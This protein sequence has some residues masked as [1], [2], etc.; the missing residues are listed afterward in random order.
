MMHSQQ[1]IK[2][3]QVKHANVLL[4]HKKELAKSVLLL[5]WSSISEIKL[6]KNRETTHRY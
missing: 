1:N 5:T 6:Q 2:F 4:L 3:V